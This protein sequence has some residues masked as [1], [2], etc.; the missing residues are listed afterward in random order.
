MVA[1]LV[2]RHS[3]AAWRRDLD[4]LEEYHE[5]LVAAT[6]DATDAA[7]A[8]QP[9]PGDQPVGQ[10]LLG[11]AIHDAYHAGQIRLLTL[12]AADQ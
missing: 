11:V 6:R 10:Q 3:D 9:A 4:L 1:G 5:R 8:R 2:G 7:L 12:A